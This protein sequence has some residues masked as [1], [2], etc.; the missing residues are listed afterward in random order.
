M[1]NIIGGVKI[2]GFISPTDTLDTYPVIDPIYGIDGLRSLSAATEMN[3][4]S[5]GRRREGMLVYLQDEKLYYK[6]LAA[7]WT[8]TIN[9]WEV[10]NSGNASNFTGGTV[11]GATNFTGG[12]TAN[13]LSA[14]TYLGLPQDVFTSGLTFN[15]GT[16][17]LTIKRNDGVNLTTNL[18]ILSSDMTIT[19]GTYNS[20]NGSATFT[21]NSGGTFTVTGFL[22]G[23][24]DTYVTGGT[25]NSSTGVLVLNR[26]NG[27]P[28]P[29]I[30]G[31]STGGTST[32][33]S[34]TGGTV[35]GATTFTGGLTANIFS[36]TT[37]QNL[38]IS[39]LTAGSNIGLT[40]YNGNYTISFTG[41]AV[42]SATNFTSGLSANTFS[43]TSIN[44]ATP[45]LNTGS[46][47]TLV[48]NTSTG[49]INYKDTTDYISQM[50]ANTIKAN[51]LSTTS[52]SFDITRDS[53]ALMMANKTNVGGTGV[54]TGIT[55]T[56]IQTI[57]LSAS[58]ILGIGSIANGVDGKTVRIFNDT[59][60][61]ITVYNEYLTEG[62]L[63]NR[64]YTGGQNIILSNLKFSEFTYDSNDSRWILSSIDGNTFIPSFSGTST[65]AVTSDSNG[66]ISA[67]YS[68][69]NP[70]LSIQYSSGTAITSA[71]KTS[72]WDLNLGSLIIPTGY[73]N[74]LGGKIF[75]KH[76]HNL[77]TGT[78]PGNITF[79]LDWTGTTLFSS[80]ALSLT[81]LTG[82]ITGGTV[83]TEVAVTTS[84]IG[85]SGVLVGYFKAVFFSSTGFIVNT[86]QKS[87]ITTSNPNLTSD[88]I[89]K[90]SITFGTGSV[91]SWVTREGHITLLN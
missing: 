14:T 28:V 10:F 6:L 53:F 8:G 47:Q 88:Q 52:T 1:A 23:Y 20:G 27:I 91:N 39:G 89:L 56:N 59:T 42:S 75:A 36:A 4:I 40:N 50:P 58:T 90:L 33:S 51:N 3:N 5:T 69:V 62:T 55:T 9:D 80:S 18:G 48:R 19:G 32:S 13:T 31:F 77:T 54:L 34:F 30:T 68:V 78:L 44:I 83:E 7:P 2:T 81:A 73:I 85:S 41:G 45:T 86:Y 67:T 84:T 72:I 17:D 82:S 71:S 70:I 46:T 63:A 87:F 57:R 22:T 61:A 35:S 21:N 74:R 49:A 26:N 11:S 66:L 76:T 60:S 16:Y 79:D 24:T 43:A 64:I 12:L 37:Y 38:P 65:R 29:D 15:N 25:Y